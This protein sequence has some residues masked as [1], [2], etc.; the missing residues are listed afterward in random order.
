MKSHPTGTF[1]HSLSNIFSEYSQKSNSSI[2]ITKIRQQLATSYSQQG[3]FD[4]N[5]PADSIEALIELLSIVHKE[6][7]MNVEGLCNGHCPSHQ[8]FGIRIK[9]CLK[10]KC[11]A[12]KT[13]NWDP[14]AFAHHVYVAELFVDVKL[15]Y[16]EVKD[17][18]LEDIS[19]HFE[20]FSVVECE[21]KLPE[22]LKKDFFTSYGICA[23]ANDDCVWKT[24][25]KTSN[26]MNI[27]RTYIIH[28]IWDYSR[29][30]MMNLLQFLAS[31]PMGFDIASLF[32]STNSQFFALH[33]FVAFGSGHYIAYIKKGSNWFS[34]DD[35]YVSLIGNWKDV[36]I[37]LLKSR[38]YPVGL[39]YTFCDELIKNAVNLEQWMELEYYTISLPQN[40]EGSPNKKVAE[41]WKCECGHFN[42]L[43]FESCEKCYMVKQGVSGWVCSFCTYLNEIQET[44]CTMCL[45]SK[46][47]I[48]SRRPPR[49]NTNTSMKLSVN[50][51]QVPNQKP[52][53]SSCNLCG[54]DIGTQY[55][56]CPV[57]LVKSLGPICTCCKTPTTLKYCEDCLQFTEFCAES[58]E[59]NITVNKK[60]ESVNGSWSAIKKPRY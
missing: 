1:Q 58:K 37:H 30:S 17:W 41:S 28:L 59:I 40:N 15:T 35:N 2:N 50:K 44:Q 33:S 16:E 4:L 12:E 3:L 38:F 7:Q 13:E 42:I 29:P 60:V 57:C 11:G 20:K 5:S 36:A 31:I 45:S 27:P 47:L 23:G 55:S 21:G 10:C 25:E 39:F 26:L 53:S 19:E 8:V 24:S 52:V 56:R 9:E 49:G 54:L 51:I 32:K 18:R 46:D 34:I 14:D 43:G 6:F 22:I 48:H